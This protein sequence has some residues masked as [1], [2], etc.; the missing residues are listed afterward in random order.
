MKYYDRN[1]ARYER[2]NEVVRSAV[3]CLGTLRCDASLLTLN[4]SVGWS[5]IIGC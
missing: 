5:P 4:L 1:I 3:G 2:C